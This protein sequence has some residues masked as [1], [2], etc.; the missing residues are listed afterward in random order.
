M[1]VNTSGE[2]KWSDFVVEREHLFLENIYSIN[3]LKVMK[4]DTT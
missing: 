1:D 4:I 2:K 3:E